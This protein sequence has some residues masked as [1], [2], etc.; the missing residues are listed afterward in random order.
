MHNNPWKESSLIKNTLSS[1][2][3]ELVVNVSRIRAIL[4][5]FSL[6]FVLFSIRLFDVAIFQQNTK[7]TGSSTNNIAITRPI[8]EDR[9][10]VLLAVDLEAASLYANPQIILDHHEAATKLVATLPELSYKQLMADFSTNKNFTWIK[11]NL[12]PKE[13]YEVNNLGIPGL[14]FE[15][16]SKRIYTQGQL[17]A[18]TLGF[19]GI[20]G[21]G[22]SGF[23]RYFDEKLA[24]NH[25]NNENIKLSIDVRIQNIVSEELSKAMSDF[26][27]I[28]AIGMVMDAKT[29]EILAAVSLPSFDPHNPGDATPEQRFN[30]FSLGLYEPGSMFKTFTFGMALDSGAITMNDVYNVDAPIKAGRFLLRDYH[31]K[32]GNLSVPEIFMYSSNIGTAKISMDL[33]KKRQLQFLKNFGLLDI[34]DIE[35]PERATPLYPKDNKWSDIS[36]MTISYGHGIAV[37]PL[38]ILSAANSMLNGGLLYKPSFLKKNSDEEIKSTRVIKSETSDSVKKLYRLV[39]EYGTGKKSNVRGYLVGGKTGTANKSSVG[40]YDLKA[41]LSSYISAFPINDPKYT[42]LVMIDEPKGNK[43][44]GG[45]A[46]AGMTAAPVSGS[47]ISRIGPILGLNFIDENNEDV[48][49]QLSID[50]QYDSD[51]EL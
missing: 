18:H 17:L 7:K 44:T 14:F 26:N 24:A 2:N 21:K 49:R 15:N 16:T 3:D 42:L 50:Y 19:T 51:H 48:I 31:G 43:A 38:H 8:I 13:Q 4:L 45:Y 5:G 28:G 29:G 12:A 37:T 47:I 22:L 27:A 1:E 46:T 33:G 25:K 35:I 20:D 41:R 40:G 34:L 9:N 6:I 11:R 32:G 30:R 36:T 23:E 10:G 39:A